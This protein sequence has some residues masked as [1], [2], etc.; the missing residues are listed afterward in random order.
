MT[1]ICGQNHI[2]PAD[3]KGPGR[4]I[5]LP[6]ALRPILVDYI[7]YDRTDYLPVQGHI[8]I[9][10]PADLN[11]NSAALR[12][13]FREM[14]SGN[15][16]QLRPKVG[17]ILFIPASSSFID[18]QI[19]HLLITRP[20]QRA[21]QITD[22]FFLC[23]E[24]L[25]ASLLSNETFDVHFSIVDPG[26]LLLYLLMVIAIFISKKVLNDH[27]PGRQLWPGEPQLRIKTP[28]DSTT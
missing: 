18:N 7:V 17:E 13:I 23:L 5:R 27:S 20:S 28:L 21:P 2:D 26:R 8:A 1:D 25:K 9:C 19:V 6:S 4:Q 11:T 24:H 3:E 14:G 10:C 16:F 22:N 12:H 15:I